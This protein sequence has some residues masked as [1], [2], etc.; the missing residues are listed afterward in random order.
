M[1]IS[2]RLAFVLALLGA[3][4]VSWAQ[5][6]NPSA[7]SKAEQERI[8]RAKEHCQQNRG[9]D[10]ESAEGLKEWLLQERSRD[11]AVREGSR[12]LLP[13]RPAPARR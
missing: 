11:E 12:H 8:Q 3:G 5:T 7:A 4:A 13:G 10:C 9:V 2:F 6:P 1:N